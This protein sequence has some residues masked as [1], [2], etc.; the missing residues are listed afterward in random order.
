MVSH[1]FDDP[2]SVVL[3]FWLSRMSALAMHHQLSLGEAA[4]GQVL[5]GV[6]AL[7]GQGAGSGHCGRN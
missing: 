2:C 4:V 3:N 7:Y 6:P 1:P 5:A